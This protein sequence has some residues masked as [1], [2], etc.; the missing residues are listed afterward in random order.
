MGA[1]HVLPE[2]IDADTARALVGNDRLYKAILPRAPWAVQKFR[3]GESISRNEA[4]AIWERE[5]FDGAPRAS[6][7]YVASH[8]LPL[9]ARYD[10]STFADREDYER[11]VAKLERRLFEALSE[12]KALRPL[13]SEA[14]QVPI[15]RGKLR[16]SSEEC[17]ILAENVARLERR[18]TE[19]R[20][21]VDRYRRDE[22]SAVAALTRRCEALEQ[23]LA[24]G[25]GRESPAESQRPRDSPR[26][27]SP[28]ESAAP[29]T[30]PGARATSPKDTT[31]PTEPS[32]RAAAS[33]N[34]SDGGSAG[35]DV[36]LAAGERR[37]AELLIAF[38]DGGG[39]LRA[40]FAKWDASG[41]GLLSAAEILKGLKGLPGKAFDG[42]ERPDVEVLLKTAGAD[43]LDFSGF[44]AFVARGRDAL[45]LRRKRISFHSSSGGSDRGSEAAE[46]LARKLG[47]LLITY[48]DGG[49]SLD[50][51]F[52][53]WDA[54]GDGELS[55]AELLAGLRKLGD[56]FVDVAKN[57]VDALFKDV[58]KAGGHASLADLTRFVAKQREALGLP[59]KAPAAFAVGARVE[60]RYKGKGK[61][62]PGTVSAYDGDGTYAVDYDDG[63]K[64]SK[65]A[66]A[67]IRGVEAKPEKS[68]GSGGAFPEGAAVEARYRGKGKFYPG[69]IAKDN[70]D[71]TYDVDYDD[72]EKESKV[73]EA[74]IRGVETKP[75]KSGGSGGAFPEGAAVEARYRGKGKFYPGK[76]A[77]DQGDGTYDIDYD[78]GEQEKGVAEALIRGVESKTEKPSAG[79]S[80][81]AFPVGGAIEA[82]YRG[83]GKFYP[84]KIAK[85]NGDGTYDVDYDDGEKESNVAEDFIRGGESK[86]EKSAGG[87]GGAFPKGGAVEARYRGKGKYYPGKI[88]KDN[89]DGTYDVDY[90]DGEKEKGVAEALIRGVETKPEK[91]S[92]GGSGGAFPEGGAIEARYRGKGKYYPG[93]IARDN[94]DG[95][96]DID[97]DDGEQEKGVT[98]ELIRGVES[99][100]EKASAGGSGGAF[101]K[102]AAVEARYRGKSKFYPGKIARDNGDG[103]YDI[104][105]DD[106]EKESKV[107]EA[108]IRGVESKPEKSGGSGGAFAE[109]A[110]VEARYRGKGKF[111]PGKI[112]KDNGDGTYNIDYDDGENEKR[113]AEALIR[114]VE[115][116]PEKSGSGG[117]F[118]EGAAVEARYRG[119]GKYYPGKIAKDNGDGTYDIDYDDGEKESKVAEALI[120]GGESKPS[121]PSAGGAG[122]AFPKGAA[123]E[124]RYRGKSKYYP[125]KIAKDNGDGTYDID[126]DDG[127]SEKKVAEA[128]IR[129]GASKPSK[130]SAGGSGGAFPK[131]GAIEARYRGKSKWYPGK[132][133][134][135]NGD[136]TYD[137]D[138][139]DGEQEKG[140]EEALIRGG[141]SKPSKP[142]AGGSGGAFPKG[143]KVEARYRGKSKWYPGKIARDNG[144]GTYDIDYDDGESEENVAEELIRG[145]AATSGS[146]GAFAVGAEVEAR[147]RGKS[148][149]YPGKIAKDNGDGTY[150]IDYDDGE[151]ESDV[152]EALI[153]ASAAT[154]S[155]GAFKVGDKIEGR[156]RGKSK[157][158]PG[159]IAKDN[160]DG[161]YDLDYDD[162]ESEKGVAEALIREGLAF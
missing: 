161:T 54:S 22:G 53:K 140:V 75:E 110:K 137:I 89:A 36:V 76:I 113:V 88:A 58:A 64:E 49:G 7:Q 18:L 39:D 69:K 6:E 41:D 146:G 129:G 61:Y 122:G 155:G 118:P 62:Y 139:D 38:E 95:T 116:K 26:S 90:D 8:E 151:K 28:P 126:Y 158:Y 121:K 56:A 132:I 23:R 104:D 84:G 25:G 3:A 48:E 162:G 128:L 72:G 42:V 159:K 100:P 47:T 83:K 60:A 80:G 35:G 124:A 117:A 160:G 134:R 73:A 57:D 106:G 79:G 87:A 149:Y 154:G 16:R 32:S 37:L 51:A 125:G 11:A 12:L 131:G 142:S 59:A 98:E 135:D 33:S 4:R 17:E 77:K 5:K 148:K 24:A 157:W 101:P 109:G 92:A 29:G 31:A 2:R 81:G 141:A 74:L 94:G 143:A 45:G 96:Y 21:D 44:E 105:Y 27:A 97:Y 153:R 65:V 93:K 46:D 82:R 103:T 138:Y 10:T 86:P 13:R 156:Y 63:E 85:D 115:S 71:G 50:S 108:L 111:Y 1:A 150:N 147:Y 43:H 70:G 52:A 68:G 145:G 91:P 30:P 20:L 66:E 102:G 78:D 34:A 14:L 9:R 133:G 114:G 144:D 19:A 136:G 67:L 99:K 55:A 152:A 15:L 120:R 123:I 107:A 127:E 119:K 130:P 112:A 40:A